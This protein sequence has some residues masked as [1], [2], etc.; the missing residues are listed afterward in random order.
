M[1]SNQ[2]NKQ[3]SKIEPETWKERAHWW[4]LE[5]RKE[6]DNGG[7]K[8]KGQVKGHVYGPMDKDNRGEDWMLEMGVGRAGEINGRVMETTVI[9]QQ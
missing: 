4:W 7:K 6:G 1:E 5:G 9:E 3:V 8:G 2:E